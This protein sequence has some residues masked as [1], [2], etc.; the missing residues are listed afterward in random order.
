MAIAT[1][2]LESYATQERVLALQS[3]IN[4]LS[5]ELAKLRRNN[6]KNN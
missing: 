3:E 5:A 2:P 6:E 4:R 1:P